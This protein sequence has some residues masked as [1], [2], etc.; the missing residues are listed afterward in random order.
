[1]FGLRK[2]YPVLPNPDPINDYKLWLTR[3]EDY[4]PLDMFYLYRIT[5]VKQFVR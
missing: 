4:D 2:D 3:V 1:M 5:Q